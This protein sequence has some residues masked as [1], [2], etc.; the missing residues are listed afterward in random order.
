LNC[1]SRDLSAALRRERFSPSGAAP[2]TSEPPERDRMRILGKELVAKYGN[3]F[4]RSA[5]RRAGRS[6]DVREAR[7]QQLLLRVAC[8]AASSHEPY[9]RGLVL[10][11]RQ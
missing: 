9:L 8:E 6:D 4:G 11:Q 5:A 10:H 1:P 2:E 7:L 3:A